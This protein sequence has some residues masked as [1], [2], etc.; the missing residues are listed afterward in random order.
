M[1]L[2]VTTTPEADA[3][4]RMI[5]D[6]WRENRRA[7][8]DL[9]LDELSRAFDTIS[10]APHIGRL[11]RRSPVPVTRRVILRGTRYHVYYVAGE[12]QVR[13][14]AVWHGERGIGPPLRVP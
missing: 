4:I 5:D 2:P 10:A 11:Y 12:E 7:S 14:L 9:F 13:V 6:W 8:P 1:S 3:Q